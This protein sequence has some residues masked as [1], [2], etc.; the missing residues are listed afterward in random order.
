MIVALRDVVPAPIPCAYDIAS[1]G[2]SAADLSAALEAT[3]FSAVQVET[4]QLTAIWESMDDALATVSG[5]LFGPSFS[6]LPTAE[7]E[8]VRLAFAQG[9]VSGLHDGRVYVSTYANVAKGIK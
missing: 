7:Q 8:R 6:A 4:A 2:L 3:G 5:S 9:L 1:Q